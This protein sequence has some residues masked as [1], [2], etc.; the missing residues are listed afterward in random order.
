MAAQQSKGLLA[1]IGRLTTQDTD[2]KVKFIIICV[3]VA[4]TCVLCNIANVHFGTLL[5]L[6]RRL[7]SEIPF[8]YNARRYFWGFALAISNCLLEIQ[9][10]K[11]AASPYVGIMLDNST[12]D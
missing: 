1:G 4:L 2:K 9:L 10:Q 5:G 12:G 7:G 6:Q 8:K 11:I 3:E